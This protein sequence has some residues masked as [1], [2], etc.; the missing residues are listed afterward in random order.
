MEQATAFSSFGSRYI[1]IGWIEFLR[2][3]YPVTAQKEVP[4]CLTPIRIPL[5]MR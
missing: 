4:S 2:H 1:S 3:F 5:K